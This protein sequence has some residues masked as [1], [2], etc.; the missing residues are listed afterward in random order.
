[1]KTGTCLATST[2]SE[3]NYIAY[4][5]VFLFFFFNVENMTRC[6]SEH[7]NPFLGFLK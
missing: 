5:V 1:M 6:I 4:S 7:V 2:L 3:D